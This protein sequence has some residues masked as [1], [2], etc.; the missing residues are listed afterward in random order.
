MK[1]KFRLTAAGAVVLVLAL[2]ILLLPPPSTAVAEG[3]SPSVSDGVAQWSRAEGATGYEVRVTFADGT[4]VF[5]SELDA[6]TT[7]LP[8][9]EMLP[10]GG[11]YTFTVT[12]KRDTE[13]LLT[14]SVTFTHTVTLSS[15][16]AL[17]FADG[18]LSW[19]A[20]NGATGYRLTLNGVDAGT[21]SSPRAD[22][23]DMLAVSTDVTASV[24]ALGDAFNLASAP[25]VYTFSF[26]AAPLPPY[27]AILAER[28]GNAVVSWT[29]SP[30][31]T[32]ECY[33]Y[34]LFCG[35][36]LLFSAKCTEN[37]ADITEHVTA[38]GSY[39]IKISSVSDAGTGAAFLFAFD[40]RDKEVAA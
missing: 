3:L 37:A 39:V 14:A 23:G 34:A 18:V 9:A 6:G 11:E 4:P 21:F 17:S 38:G 7:F 1:A 36:E 30:D 16:H 13:T 12:A 24:T 20:T 33:V 2:C 27:G 31:E 32:T 25:A 35:D 10:K 15:P 8:V 40:V 29:P 28:D 19:S 22:I 5:S 26:R